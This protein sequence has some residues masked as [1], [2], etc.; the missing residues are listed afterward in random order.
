M[1]DPTPP[2][3]QGQMRIYDRME[4]PLL[5]GAH[6]LQ[7]Q[8]A[9]TYDGGAATLPS[10]RY[11]TVDGPRFTLSPDEVASVLPPRNGSGAF[12]EL[13]PQIV[14]H[15]RTLPWERSLGA[16]ASSGAAPGAGDPPALGG[17]APWLALLTLVD[18][19]HTLLE[20]IP[21][22]QILPADVL[23]RLAPPGGVVCDAVEVSSDVLG[24]VLAS[25][26]ELALLTHVRRVNVLDRASAGNDPDGWFAVVMSNRLP[27]PGTKCHCYL[28]SV[29]GRTDLVPAAPPPSVE[30]VTPGRPSRALDAV[31]LEGLAA[32][33]R[34]RGF[35]VGAT[36]PPARRRLVVLHHWGFDAIAGGGTFRERMQALDVGLFGDL[37]A[38]GG[39]RATDTGHVALDLH[40][41]AGAVESVWYRGPLCAQPL[42]RDAL[43]PYHSADQARRIS[44][45]TGAEDIT[46]AAAFEA[47]R[48]IAAADGRLAQ[49]LAR[50][51]RGAYDDSA[52][53]GTL[54]AVQAALPLS[55]S[56]AAA[57]PQAAATTIAVGA[58]AR[59]AAAAPAADA[60]GLQAVAAAPG[61]D[62]QAVAAAWGLD[63]AGATAILKGTAPGAALPKTAVAAPPPASA[64]EALARLGVARAALVTPLAVAA[65]SLAAAA[66]GRPAVPPR[67]R[68]R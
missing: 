47:G 17:D 51:R 30:G 49:D 50:W 24:G 66:T 35:D 3:A 43:G 34:A 61:L 10:E 42:T 36:F 63:S 39:P 58:L 56:L 5:P 53:G 59:F 52:R 44:P 19:E 13:L 65:P 9:V 45:E 32:M 41:R 1:A 18:G 25:R 6:R 15:R 38:D 57:L 37:P 60:S 64:A 12:S 28:V 22:E 31:A 48:L 62:A 26:E 33:P 23:A 20:S 2:P 11:F 29:E 14:L 4:L 21:L 54:A 68:K 27:P 67:R 40:D 16:P 7:A 46:Y 55:A 8:V